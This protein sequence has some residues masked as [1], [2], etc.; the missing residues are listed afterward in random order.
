MPWSTLRVCSRPAMPE[1]FKDMPESIAERKAF[2]QNDCSQWAPRDALINILRQ[3]DS[4]Q[5]N[6]D[7][8]VVCWFEHKD[9]KTYTTCRRSRA[10]VIE[11]IGLLELCKHDILSP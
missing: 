2:L 11:V 7:G 3:I 4:G 8:M 6:P 5:I 1:N 9:D 10:T